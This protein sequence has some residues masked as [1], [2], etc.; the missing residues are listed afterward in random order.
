[1]LLPTA[2]GGH[3]LC[4]IA[5][6]VAF[7]VPALARQFW[8]HY[9][10]SSRG[11]GSR[12]QRQIVPPCGIMR[13]REEATGSTPAAREFATRCGAVIYE[14]ENGG[15]GNRTLVSDDASICSG[16]E[17]AQCLHRLA[18]L[19]L[20]SPDTGK[21]EVAR[22]GRIIEAWPTLPDRTKLVIESMCL[23]DRPGN[24]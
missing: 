6:I 23:E 1:M 21:H 17:L 5:P 7:K 8:L 18:A 14:S 22:I 20:Q 13:Q 24:L 9:G 2:R 11:L 3:V 4:R 12:E 19:W 15:G 16:N 10:C